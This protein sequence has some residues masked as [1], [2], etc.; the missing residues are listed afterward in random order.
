MYQWR[1]NEWFIGEETAQRI[2]IQTGNS[3]RNH[4]GNGTIQEWMHSA[5]GV[6]G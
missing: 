5:D 4:I 2:K 1:I 3:V 6:G